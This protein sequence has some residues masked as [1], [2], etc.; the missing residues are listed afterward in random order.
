MLFELLCIIHVL[1]WI[2]V[3]TAFLN[4][5]LA[6]YNVYYVIPIIYILHILQF[7]ILNRLKENVD[8]ENHVK[9]NNEVSN[10]LI[11]PNLFDN[12]KN[13]FQKF[14]FANPLSGQGMLIFGLLT[15]IFVL[16]P[17]KY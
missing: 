6:Y 2:F 5:K 3:L 17:P 8:P 1:I 7:H 11:L 13:N 14:S 4:K 9:R 10:F 12:I 15:S 16:H